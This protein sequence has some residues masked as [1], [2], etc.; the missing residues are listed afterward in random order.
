MKPEI[1]IYRYATW[2]VWLVQLVLLAFTVAAWLQYGWQTGTIFAGVWLG[3]GIL[4]FVL[5]R[6]Y[7]LEI[8]GDT[9]SSYDWLGR[10]RRQVTFDQVRRID[11]GGNDGN[12]MLITD[13]G[14]ITIEYLAR[15]REIIDL[16]RKKKPDIKMTSRG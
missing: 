14:P 1:L 6:N 3:S 13:E 12:T 4:Q 7:R 11:L 15:E 5:L 9:L 8:E 16:F 10:L 2:R